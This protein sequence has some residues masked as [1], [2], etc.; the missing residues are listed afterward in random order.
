MVKKEK[1]RKSRFV[2]KPIKND[3]AMAIVKKLM[4]KNEKTLEVLRY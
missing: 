4:K 2:G 3:E 1:S